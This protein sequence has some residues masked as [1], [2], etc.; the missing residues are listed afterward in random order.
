MEER[1]KV[2]AE[3]N[4]ARFEPS[5]PV[6]VLCKGSGSFRYDPGRAHLLLVDVKTMM[7][8]VVER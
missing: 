6:C 4:V 8:K 7:W 5:V 3:G 2:V 1:E